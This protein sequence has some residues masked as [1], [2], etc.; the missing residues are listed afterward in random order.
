MTIAS[1]LIVSVSFPLSGCITDKELR[2]VNDR[3][4]PKMQDMFDGMFKTF[5]FDVVL[6]VI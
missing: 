2:T 4:E 3:T 1:N 6:V 5:I